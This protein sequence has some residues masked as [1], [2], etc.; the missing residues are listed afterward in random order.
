ML[1]IKYDL[2]GISLANTLSSV[3]NTYDLGIIDWIRR[4]TFESVSFFGEGGGAIAMNSC[5]M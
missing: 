5:T 3:R 1:L 2:A 4:S